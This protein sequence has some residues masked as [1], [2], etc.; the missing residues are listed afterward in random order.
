M[1]HITYCKY[2]LH[3]A[4]RK[5]EQDD[6]KNHKKQNI[7]MT[8]NFEYSEHITKTPE[9]KCHTHFFAKLVSHWKHKQTD[10]GYQ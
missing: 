1:M 3:L 2:Q 7:C 4:C 8:P 9:E 10:T 5:N 6:K